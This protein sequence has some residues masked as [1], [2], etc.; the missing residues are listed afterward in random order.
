MSRFYEVRTR[1]ALG[2]YSRPS[3]ASM[4]RMASDIVG[5]WGRK[6]PNLYLGTAVRQEVVTY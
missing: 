1:N 4:S 6:F 2:K 5:L 3:L